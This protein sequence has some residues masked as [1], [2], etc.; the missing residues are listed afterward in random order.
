MTIG[1]HPSQMDNDMYKLM[2]NNLIR[3]YSNKCYKHFGYVYK[4]YDFEKK[5]NGALV[6]EDSSAS[7]KYKVKI[8][9]KLCKPLKGSFIVCEVK[10]INKSLI[11]VTNGPI[12]CCIFEG[13]GNI[14]QDNFVFDNN[15][16]M[17]FGKIDNKHV[18]I[19][20]GTFVEIKVID[21]QIEHNSTR[22]IIKGTLERVASK[23]ATMD[24]IKERESKDV[25]F[26]EYDNYMQ[27]EDDNISNA[28]ISDDKVSETNSISLDSDLES[29]E[30]DDN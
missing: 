3:R 24:A 28:E 19:T 8:S 21:S 22:L 30:D 23:S 18:P 11:Y 20:Q 9:C 7:A 17:L 15:K 6:A 2:K 25:E 26:M 29:T 1:L 13:T 12:H 14:N 10:A 16:T 4:I 5:S 27:T